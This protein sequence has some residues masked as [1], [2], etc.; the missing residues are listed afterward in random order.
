MRR[1]LR[2]NIVRTVLFDLGGF[3]MYK[4]M[5]TRLLGVVAGIVLFAGLWLC[6]LPAVARKVHLKQANLKQLNQRQPPLVQL[7]QIQLNHQQNQKKQ[8][9]AVV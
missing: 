5:E 7:F 4:I 6:A 8:L 2:K 3:F 1:V 9:M